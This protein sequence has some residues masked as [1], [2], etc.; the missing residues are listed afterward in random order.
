MRSLRWSVIPQPLQQPLLLAQLVA[1][2][3]LFQLFLG[4][5]GRLLFRSH[6]CLLWDA[7]GAVAAVKRPVRAL[8]R[9]VDV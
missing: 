2:L 4:Q 6:L 5:L 9:A 8:K 7:P 1:L 3:K